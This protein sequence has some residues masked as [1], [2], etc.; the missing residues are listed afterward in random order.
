MTRL[1][2]GTTS[3][4]EVVEVDVFGALFT[5]KPVTRSVQKVLE[6]VEEEL[7]GATTGDQMADAFAEGLGALLAP[8]NGNRA[9]AKKLIS[10]KWKADELSL[11][12]ITRFFTDLQEASA[13]PT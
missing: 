3:T 2:L 8:A 5:L 7:Q 12:Q 9:G 13:P 1:A 11:D 6:K 10:D 4:E